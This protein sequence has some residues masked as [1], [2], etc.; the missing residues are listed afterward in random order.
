[1][2]CASVPNDFVIH[3]WCMM[4]EDEMIVTLMREFTGITIEETLKSWCSEKIFSFFLM[5]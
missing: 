1:M 5:L 4:E 2:F 3:V